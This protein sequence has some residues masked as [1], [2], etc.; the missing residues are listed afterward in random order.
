MIPA[1]KKPAKNKAATK[2]PA[3][4]KPTKKKPAAKKPTKKKAAAKKPANHKYSEH[5]QRVTVRRG[6]FKDALYSSLGSGLGGAAGWMGGGYLSGK[7][8]QGVEG[9]FN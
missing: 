6:G 1:A 4:K 3:A 7:A 9:M 5:D 2:K 8:I